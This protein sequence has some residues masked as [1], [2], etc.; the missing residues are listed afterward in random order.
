MTRED[1]IH[2]K[3]QAD[4]S[5]KRFNAVYIPMFFLLLIGNVFFTKRLPKGIFF[6]LLSR[7]FRI[8]DSECIFDVMD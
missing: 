1:F 2:R 7:I 3:K 6:G 8:F 5:G 4:R